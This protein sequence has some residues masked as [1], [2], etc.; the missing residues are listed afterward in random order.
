MIY[1]FLVI[2]KYNNVEMWFVLVIIYKYNNVEVESG[3]IYS[4]LVYCLI[5][6]YECGL[7]YFTIFS[8]RFLCKNNYPNKA[9]YKCKDLE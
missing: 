6:E 3:D 5:R 2:Y 9:I 4:I 8:M 1:L 7:S